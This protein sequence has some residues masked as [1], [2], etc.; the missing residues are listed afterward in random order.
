MTN[1]ELPIVIYSYY[2]VTGTP[3]NIT[4]AEVLAQPSEPVNS[5][6]PK[7]SGI[8]ISNLDNT[9]SGSGDIGGIIWGPVEWPISNLT[10]VCITNTAPKT[11]DLYNVY[12]VKIIDSQFNFSSGN[13][14]TLCNAGIT[15]SNT[16]PGVV[17][18][19]F[20]GATST[21]SMAF[22]N[23]SSSMSSA[24]LFAAN[25]VTISGGVLSDTTNL[26]LPA[27]TTQNFVLGTNSSTIAVTGNLTLDSTLNISSGA[28]F[29][30]TNYTLFT[31]TGSLSAAPVLG[32]TPTGFEG[33]TYALNTSTAGEVVL[34]VSP[35]PPPSFST[36]SFVSSNG[37]LIFS[38]TGGVIN[39][40][41]YVL[42]ATNIALPLNQWLPVATNHFDGSGNFIFTNAAQTNVPQTYF[43]L[44]IP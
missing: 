22:Y 32:A 38:G 39:G 29:T 35:P 37:S 18:D 17:V 5:T 12:G 27:S 11:F 43:L 2:S 44:E 25:P 31:Y 13:T 34:V 26:A 10:L 6:T 15:I 30:A 16:I 40:A 33:Y 20:T 24:N 9:S 8:T 41:Y 19:S 42:T 1:V 21:N 28:G 14:F 7:W 23:A 4:T 36:S 3:N